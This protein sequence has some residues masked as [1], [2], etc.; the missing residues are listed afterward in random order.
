MEMMATQERMEAI[1]E[2][3]RLNDPVRV[4]HLKWLKN[5]LHGRPGPFVL[6]T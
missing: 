4:Q 1:D 2:H 6:L 5:A 3:C